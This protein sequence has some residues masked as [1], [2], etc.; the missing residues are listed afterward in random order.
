MSPEG[1]HPPQR[2]KQASREEAARKA[3][4]YGLKASGRVS[5]ALDARFRGHDAG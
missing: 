5:I 3:G 1:G 4:I 2:G